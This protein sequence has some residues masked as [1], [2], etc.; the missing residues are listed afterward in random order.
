MVHFILRSAD[1][2][3]RVRTSFEV[4]AAI[5]PDYSYSDKY[6]IYPLLMLRI[7]IACR[8]V[9]RTLGRAHL[10]DRRLQNFIL[11]LSPLCYCERVD[12]GPSIL[13]L[14]R[15]R[16]AINSTTTHELLTHYP[17]AASK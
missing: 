1:V 14:T 3:R 12:S 6:Y 11:L 8:F 4:S 2:S 10:T 15:F 5:I 13:L 9:Y 7:P 16:S 17:A